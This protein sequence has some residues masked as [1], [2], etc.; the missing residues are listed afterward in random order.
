MSEEFILHEHAASGNCYKI[1]L[2]AAL[3]PITQSA[4]R[5]VVAG[6]E[7]FLRQAKGTAHDP[8]LRNALHPR[9][10]FVCERAL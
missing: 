1:R 6:S 3:F 2:T 10:L 9:Q 5:N 7:N 8:N 4:E